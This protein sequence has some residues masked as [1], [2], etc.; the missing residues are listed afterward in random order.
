MNLLKKFFVVSVLAF[1]LPL[2][3][4]AHSVSLTFTKSVDDT[5]ATGQGYTT[6]RQSGTCPAS[7]TSTT[8]FTSLNSTLF[9][10]SSY[11]DSTV[12]PGNYC[13]IVTFTAASA[14]SNP[15]NTAAAVILPAAPTNVTVT[16]TN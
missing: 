5:G 9:T 12:T 13:Y 8:G 6:W 14:V 1:A 3:A 10:G 15:S 7:V 16:G 11:T 4:S 2:M